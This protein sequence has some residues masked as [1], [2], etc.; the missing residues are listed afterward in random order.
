MPSP[1]PLRRRPVMLWSLLLA[2]LILTP[3][4]ALAK[5]EAP[6]TSSLQMLTSPTLGG[7]F[8]VIWAAVPDITPVASTLTFIVESPDGKATTST[9]ALTMT[10]GRASD[11]TLRVQTPKAG[12]YHI[13]AV[14]TMTVRNGRYS[15]VAGLDV[16]LSAQGKPYRTKERVLKA[17]EF[18]AKTSS[19]AAPMKKAAVPRALSAA[20]G[21]TLKG[22]FRF[23]NKLFDANGFTGVRLDPIRRAK[24]LVYETT[25]GITTTSLGFTTTTDAGAFTFSIPAADHPRDFLVRLASLGATAEVKDMSGGAYEYDIPIVQ[26]PGGTIDFGTIT[27]NEEQSGPWNIFDA[28]VQGAGYLRALTGADP[29]LVH[30]LWAVGNTD[31]TYF[32]PAGNQINILGS[33]RDSDEFDDAVILHEYGHFVATNYSYDRSSGGQHSWNGH[34]T[35]TL[36]W[37]E[38]WGTFFSSLVRDT[39]LYLDTNVYGNL[40]LDIEVPTGS[41]AGD[42]NEGAVAASLWDIYD[43][44]DDNSDTLSDGIAHIWRVMRTFITFNRGC[45]IRDLY[46]GWLSL[47]IGNIPQ[48]QEILKEHG[49]AYPPI[50]VLK[51]ALNNGAAVSASRTVTLNSACV[52]TPVAYKVSENSE[53]KNAAWTPYSNVARYTFSAGQGNKG[54]YFK[55]KDAEGNE[56]APVL[57]SIVIGAIPLTPVSLDGFKFMGNI[58]NEFDYDMYVFTIKNAGVYTIDTADMGLED[59]VMEL[60]GPNSQTTR[61]ESNDDGHGSSGD[62][63]SRIWRYLTP[64]AYYVK[65]KG[66]GSSTGDYSFWVTAGSPDSAIPLL[67]INGPDG[68][69]S[70][71]FSE[72]RDTNWFRIVVPTAGDYTIQTIENTTA[73]AVLYDTRMRLFGPDSQTRL[74]AEDDDGGHTYMSLIS[75]RLEPGVYYV[76]VDSY[77]YNISG[78]YLIRATTGKSDEIKPL[79][80]NA[81]ATSDAIST[82]TTFR[83]Y[84]FQ[85]AIPG[86][87]TIETLASG[88]TDS[89][90]FLYG[91][92]SRTQFMVENDDQQGNRMAAI[93][94]PF[95]AGT[96]YFKVEGSGAQALGSYRVRVK[97]A[98]PTT[99]LPAYQWVGGSVS[100]ATPRN[101]F[102]F[103]VTQAM[104]YTLQTAAGSLSD[105][106]LTLYGPNDPLQRIAQN[107]DVDT[108]SRLSQLTLFLKPGVY[109]ALVEGYDGKAFG[110]YQLR[111]TPVPFVLSKEL[112][113]NADPL[114]AA[115]SYPS[116]VD[117]YYFNVASGG[118]YVIETTPGTLKSNALRIYGPGNQIDL[119]GADGEPGRT[120][121]CTVT[122]TPG[123]YYI[124]TQGYAASDLGTYGIQVRTEVQP[125]TMNGPART[126]TIASASDNHWFS[127]RVEAP[128]SFTIETQAG[129]LQDSYMRLYGPNGMDPLLAS[130]NDQGPGRMSAITRALTPGT[131]YV[132]VRGLGASDVGSY[133]VSVRSVIRTLS[134]DGKK[135]TGRIETPN[136]TDWYSFTVTRSRRYTIAT[137]A[138]TLHD[139]AIRLFGPNDSTA[140]VAQDNDSGKGRMSQLSRV[141]APGKYYLAVTGGTKV[142]IGSYTVTVTRKK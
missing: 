100:A 8:D 80:V 102:R 33:S 5:T 124:R 83:W 45:T 98:F 121:K 46:D 137:N 29:P 12:V 96:Y 16:G 107:D 64:G 110:D 37:S 123:L 86:D 91:P 51:L 77:S 131:Y 6:V 20:E 25:P 109:Y 59:S 132:K 36:A 63:M 62:Y 105:T 125:L 138:G 24:V 67:K 32:I 99:P 117:W 42:D 71:D 104:G 48:L 84:S 28:L 142:S 114:Q 49:I 52:G 55:V 112:T 92:N 126:R 72:G 136:D 73:N 65:V 69:G 17:K 89:Y 7:S 22:S 68:H 10:R 133:S 60:Y 115:I 35:P 85:I 78:D 2:L 116:E 82:V 97:S 139:S 41:V 53:F 108:K 129:T 88:L 21:I 106:V 30:C 9:R 111:L 43:S 94:H 76:Q 3:G 40:S 66:F 23:T 18:A 118:S 127:F 70:I 122:L 26:W 134:T 54:V 27:M 113:V 135:A 95:T 47:R 90:L 61:I 31:G 50:V 87:Y 119:V 75:R 141:L 93:T 15:Q 13:S 1:S 44:A 79:A 140:I 19:K 74:L 34:Y 128:G 39:P 81:A 57:D 101:W 56:S 4:L 38:G 14:L 120:A 58:A 11:A 130:D 103:T